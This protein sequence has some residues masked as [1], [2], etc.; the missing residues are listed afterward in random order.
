MDVSSKRPI[1][2]IPGI[3]DSTMRNLLTFIYTGEVQVADEMLDQLLQAAEMLEIRGLSNGKADDLE[4]SR[5]SILD[6]T[7]PK[8][9]KSQNILSPQVICKHSSNAKF[10]KLLFSRTCSMA[11]R[12]RITQHLPKSIA[13]PLSM[14][15]KSLLWCL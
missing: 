10:P 8:K 6:I 12:K 3:A 4:T 14:R 11:R 1:L 15:R 2:S 5:E 7:S 9:S 13:A